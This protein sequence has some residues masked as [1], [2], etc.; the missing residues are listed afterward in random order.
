MADAKDFTDPLVLHAYV[1]NMD[2]GNFNITVPWDDVRCVYIY[3][4]VTTAI[5]NNGAMVLTFKFNSSSG[6]TFAT[7]TVAQ[8]ESVGGIDEATISNASVAA[9][10][11][12]GS[13]INIGVN[14]DS[15]PAGAVNAWF[16]FEPIL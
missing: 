5:D 12:R 16:Y 10:F 7:M 14:G 8:N 15:S 13:F 2:S 9:S 3:S 6:T 11:A 4:V 1:P